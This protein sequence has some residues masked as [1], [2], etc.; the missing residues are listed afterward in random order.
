MK[1]TIFR[2][3]I[4]VAAMV[5]L[6][7]AALIFFGIRQ[8]VRFSQ[9]QYLETAHGHMLLI[10]GSPVSMSGKDGRFK[11]LTTGDKVLVAHSSIAES[12]P[13]RAEAYLCMKKSDGTASD[14]PSEVLQSLRE[15][16]WLAE[17]KI[18]DGKTVT[19][20]YGC[21]TMSLTI[22]KNW[23]SQTLQPAE[24]LTMYGIVFGPKGSE[25]TMAL[26]G[27]PDGVGFCGTDI[28]FEDTLVAG[29]PASV[30]YYHQDG[31]DRL[32]HIYFTDIPGDFVL[33]NQGLSSYWEQYGEQ[34]M[35][36]AETVEI[37]VDTISKDEAER[38]A[39][40]QMDW[41]YYA[42][43]SQLDHQS[44]DWT[45]TFWSKDREYAN[46]VTVSAD[47]QVIAVSLPE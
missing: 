10:D 46:F 25:A 35:Q 7:A 38:I 37:R 4:V 23:E 6:A 5:L 43:T 17:Q 27:Y 40:E 32:D 39:K 9:A 33:I 11:N 41:D 1:K 15:L 26:C 2:I 42:V 36:I 12:Y 47:G 44:G 24:G 13:G 20:E 34:I 14:I 31:L 19:Y 45:V 8:G 3:A 28:T 22:P 18:E 29:H 21:V 16:G 30:A